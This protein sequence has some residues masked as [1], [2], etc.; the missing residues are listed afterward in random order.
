MAVEVKIVVD[1][2]LGL[3]S[4]DAAAKREQGGFGNY[5]SLHIESLTF[6]L[7]LSRHN[8]C[9]TLHTSLEPDSNL[10]VVVFDV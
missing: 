1:E 7:H 3:P 5:C 4:T 6:G 9:K 2:N 10:L 8:Y